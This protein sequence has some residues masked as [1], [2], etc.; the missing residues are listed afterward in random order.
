MRYDAYLMTDEVVS[1]ELVNG[2]KTVSTCS[3]P[4]GEGLVYREEVRILYS[5]TMSMRCADIL[6]V[7]TA[8]EREFLSVCLVLL[9]ERYEK[10]RLRVK[11]RSNRE[12]RVQTTKDSCDKQKLSEM[13]VS[14]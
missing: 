3:P 12:R 2:R 10:R 8:S 5:R 13:Y 4:A 6:D 11:R 1:A 7:P 9:A 14:R